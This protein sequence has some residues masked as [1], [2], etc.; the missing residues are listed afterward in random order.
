MPP[1][2]DCRRDS[3]AQATTSGVLLTIIGIGVALLFVVI[4]AGISMNRSA[5][6]TQ[7]RLIDKALSGRVERTLI[8]QQ[9]WAFW[10]EAARNIAS[11]PVPQSWFDRQFGVPLRENYRHEQVYI[12]GPDDR[13]AY[14][15]RDD[16]HPPAQALRTLWPSIAP[17]IREIRTG[18]RRGY[19]ARDKHFAL[20]ETRYKR[21]WSA[22]FA[23]WAAN[24]VRD[25]R[26]PVIVAIM[27]ILPTVDR[28]VDVRRPYLLMSV[29]RLDQQALDSIGQSIGVQGLKLLEAGN[30]SANMQLATDDRRPIGALAWQVEQPGRLMLTRILPIFAILLLLATLYARSNFHR[31]ETAQ[32]RL[33]DEEAKARF[34]SLHDSLSGLPN[35]RMFSATL[36]ARLNATPGDPQRLCVAYIDVDRFKDV[37]DAIGHG[38]GDAL[39]MEIGPRLKS[40]LRPND[41]L[42]RLGGDEFAVLRDLAEGESAEA[43]GE[44]LLAAFKLP[45]TIA[46][47][48][49]EVT[50]SVGLAI[51]LP[52]ETEPERLLQDADITLYRAKDAGRNRYMLFE[53]AMADQVRS[54]HRIERDLRSAIGT[55]QIHIHYQPVI[56]TRSGRVTS[57]EALVRWNHPERGPISPGEFVPVAEHCGLMVPLGDH[58]LESVFRECASFPDVEVAINLSPVQLRMRHLPGRLAQLTRLFG[59]DPR[60]II[61]EITESMLVEAN[62][63]TCEVFENLRTLG[64]RTALDDFGTGYS[65]LG[66]LHQFAFDKIKIDRSFISGR[67]L[68]RLRPIIEGIVHI[69]RGL[70][71]DIV[72]EGV[73]TAE[74]FAMIQAMG[75]N[76]AQGYWISKPLPLKDAVEFLASSDRVEL[77]DQPLRLAH[78]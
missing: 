21:M 29:A 35:R 65:S 15:Y 48:Q 2:P 73:E 24:I 34:Q 68:G 59:V 37:N 9:G 8:E 42:A 30:I 49:L 47:H 1:T 18:E 54:R 41:L 61:L 74:E 22:P 19:V 10:D 11:R 56:S 71:M 64:F 6:E 63:A 45:F 77:A 46:G 43:L 66:Y 33:R 38:A 67:S 57:V 53:P 51:A 75:C 12:L 50:A 44:A 23:R 76:E 14:A 36:A 3:K 27:T 78:G 40:A 70:R 39:V 7:R 13:V 5:Y 31:L 60:R 55:S 32:R 26:G 72:A 58:I 69:G 52:G 20:S 25:D 4:Y 28:T 17:M 62:E 16:G